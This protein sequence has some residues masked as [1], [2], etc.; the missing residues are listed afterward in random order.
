MLSLYLECTIV[1]G[2]SG[3]LSLGGG[4]VL[5]TSRRNCKFIV[6][7]VGTYSFEIVDDPGADIRSTLKDLTSRY[8]FSKVQ[9]ILDE[10]EGPHIE[11]E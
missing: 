5:Q 7:D 2:S 10:M 9:S 4:F 6:P 3:N 11:T 8:G 1:E